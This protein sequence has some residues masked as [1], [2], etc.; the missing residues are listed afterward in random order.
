MLQAG[1]TQGAA[2]SRR[3]GSG[4]GLE[5]RQQCARIGKVDSGQLGAQA[6]EPDDRRRLEAFRLPG[7][8]AKADLQP[9][10]E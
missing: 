3:V 2:G 1:R 6:S 9:V 4:E 10:A 8:E 7:Q 5:R